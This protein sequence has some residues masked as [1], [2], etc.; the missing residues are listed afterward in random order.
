M[1][2]LKSLV[3]TVG[4]LCLLATG[5]WFAADSVRFL[6]GAERAA[7]VV[8]R[9]VAKRGVRGAKL[10]HPVVRYQ[11]GNG[12]VQVE[13]TARPGL[14]PAIFAAGDRVT[15]AFRAEDPDG[16]RI[17]SFWM[18]WFLPLVCALLGAACLF[19][20]WHTARAAERS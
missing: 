20:G 18:L 13:F 2:R 15:V 6:D 14:F 12:T 11:P 9:I 10:Y 17:V 19:A 7:G 3:L 8:V 4:G 1:E 16:A 5:G